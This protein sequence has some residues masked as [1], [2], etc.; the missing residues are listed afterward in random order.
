MTRTLQVFSLISTLHLHSSE[1][2][3]LH[4]SITYQS[5]W[6]SAWNIKFVSPVQPSPAQP[7]Q[8]CLS[9]K[10]SPCRHNF[11]SP[12]RV[13]EITKSSSYLPSA[14]RELQ[15]LARRVLP[16]YLGQ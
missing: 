10:T 2:N 5:A 11:S 3:K 4:H 12:W 13:R 9:I 16:Y 7:G 6:M 14:V 15:R 1:V 8:V